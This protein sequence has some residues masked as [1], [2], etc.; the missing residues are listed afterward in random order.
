MVKL[1]VF[2]TGSFANIYLN[3]D[4]GLASKELLN[5]GETSEGAFM[6]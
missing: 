5:K 3:E 6:S 4:V 1:A 2:G